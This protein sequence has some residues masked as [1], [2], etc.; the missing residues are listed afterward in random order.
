ML[1]NHQEDC[2]NCCTSIVACLYMTIYAY[3]GMQLSRGGSPITTSAVTSYTHSKDTQKLHAS[4]FALGMLKGVRQHIRPV[5][6]PF[7]CS[8]ALRRSFSVTAMVR[9]D[10]FRP[11]KRVAGQKQDVW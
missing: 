5:E 7:A 9:E 1:L 11:A 4:V 8:S 2:P 3:V 6:Y 10:P